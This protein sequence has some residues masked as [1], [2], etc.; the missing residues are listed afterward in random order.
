MSLTDTHCHLD[1]DRYQQDREQVITEAVEAGL[2]RMLNPGI[3]VASSQA[4]IQLAQ[5]NDRVYAAVGVHPNNS[6]TWEAS[7]L[8]ALLDMAAH[9]KVVAIGEIGLDYYRDRAPRYVQEQVFHHQLTLAAELALPVIIHNREAT[10]D[11]LRML[12][13]WHKTLV[14]SRSPLVERPGVLHSYSGN[15]EQAQEAMGLNFYLGFTGPVTFHNAP[16]LQE[17]VKQLPLDQI[18]IETDAPFLTP[19][20]HRGRRN[21]P[22]HVEL[23]AE[24]IAALHDVPLAEVAEKTRTNAARLFNW[25]VIN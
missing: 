2:V 21:H 10:D 19:H 16:E 11:I 18:L 17:V 14:E 20:P 22:K 15:L 24:K 6:T 23:I 9:A 3:D 1:F 13:T 7:T 25:E 8:P 4:A 12:T 5:D